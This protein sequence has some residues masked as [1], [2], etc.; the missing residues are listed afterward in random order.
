M[1][2]WRTNKYSA[3]PPNNSP[4]NR[5]TGLWDSKAGPHLSIGKT[6][7]KVNRVQ[8][9]PELSVLHPVYLAQCW[10]YC[11]C[12]MLWGV[13]L[14]PC[15]AHQNPHPYC[16]PYHCGPLPRNL[17]SVCHWQPICGESKGASRLVGG[18][19]WGGVGQWSFPILAYQF[20]RISEKSL[21][22]HSRS[23]F[24]DWCP[25]K[26]ISDEILPADCTDI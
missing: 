6:Q 4:N 12:T 20:S 17:F 21:M 8:S 7:H 15:A 19:R 18:G 9:S 16:G 5:I 13:L 11:R 3:M 24:C 1:V 23:R 26:I 25:P 14:Q 22:K 10:Y 2:R